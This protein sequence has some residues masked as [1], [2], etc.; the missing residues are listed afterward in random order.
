M[1]TGTNIISFSLWGNNPKYVD[2]AIANL[3]LAPVIYPEWK[4]RIYVD[5]SVHIDTLKQLHE[6]GAEIIQISDE[7]GP[8]YGMYWRFFV[9]D[10]PTV[11]RYIVRDLDSRLNWREKA[12]VD[13]WISEG[14]PVHVMRDHPHHTFPIQGG[15]WGGT[16][17]CVNNM[18]Q[19]ICAWNQY[20]RYACDQFFL[21]NIIWPLVKDQCTLHDPI[22]SNK[23][24]PKHKPIEDG[25]TFVGQIYLKN[26]P[27]LA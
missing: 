16:F 20:D 6:L 23:P 14:T 22:F 15:M 11:N 21:G 4:C 19:K 7:R 26:I 8:F 2:G 5:K 13:E 27:Q 10:D 1:K 25:G 24:F 9:N 17:N 18:Y 3:K 12:A